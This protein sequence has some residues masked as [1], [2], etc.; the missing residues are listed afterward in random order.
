MIKKVNINI[1]LLFLGLIAVAVLL[2][3]FGLSKVI[4][5]SP[6]ISI[7]GELIPLLIFIFFLFVEVGL[8]T[9]S[10]SVSRFWVILLIILTILLMGMIIFNNLSFWFKPHS[11]GQ[12]FGF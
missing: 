8:Y 12:L 2:M 7:F 1:G 10:V 3:P 4:P 5:G 9:K 6:F 11:R